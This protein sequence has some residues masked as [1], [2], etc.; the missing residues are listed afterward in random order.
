[1]SLSEGNPIAEPITTSQTQTQ[2][3]L[4][5]TQQPPVQQTISDVPVNNTLSTDV[6]QA[7]TTTITTAT[8]SPPNPN[9]P[10]A[11]AIGVPHLAGATN[12]CPPQVVMVLQREKGWAEHC[13]CIFL[14]LLITIPVCII[15]I[16]YIPIAYILSPVLYPIARLLRL[17]FCCR[18]DG[19]T[20]DSSNLANDD[21]NNPGSGGGPKLR[22]PGSSS[23]QRRQQQAPGPPSQDLSNHD[24]TTQDPTGE[25]TCC[26]EITLCARCTHCSLTCL[27]TWPLTCCLYC[28]Y[29]PGGL[30]NTLGKRG[31]F[32]IVGMDQVTGMPLAP[33]VIGGS[34]NGGFV[35]PST[36]GTVSVAGPGQMEV[37]SGIPVV[38]PVVS[39]SLARVGLL[40]GPRGSSPRTDSNSNSLGGVTVG[41]SGPGGNQNLVFNGSIPSPTGAITSGRPSGTTSTT[42]NASSN[43]DE[44]RVDMRP[45]L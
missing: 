40:G 17:I 8:Q 1:M 39:N 42:N 26:N 7:G 43:P 24:Q 21:P 31:D 25:Q 14:F 15:S 19:L 12:P 16:L 13:P 23:S 5:A 28:M 32:I 35:A 10:G 44:V 9:T 29:E 2:S 37:V 18:T 38:G 36:H 3:D 22:G 45:T 34:S 6:A 30:K 33:G 11:V 27:S 20:A 4:P 41:G